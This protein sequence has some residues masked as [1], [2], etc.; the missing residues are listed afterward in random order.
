MN[1]LLLGL[2]PL[3]AFGLLSAALSAF[4]FL[5]YLRDT[6]RGTTQPQRAAW[7][8]WSILGSIAFSSQV[9]EGASHSL[10]FAGAQVGGT[11]L[12]FVL[13]IPCGAGGFLSARDR[14][15]VLLAAGGL[16]RGTLPIPP[17]TRWRSQSL[18]ACWAGS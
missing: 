14:W 7:L 2:D 13:S 18:S 5:P 11:I 9:F 1:D 6:L 8:I 16:V 10:W 12:V 3:A 15:I 17:S 4:A